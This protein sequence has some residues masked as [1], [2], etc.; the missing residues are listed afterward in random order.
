[1]H[2]FFLVLA[3]ALRGL[4]Y[5]TLKSAR[6]VILAEV[7]KH[8]LEGF[9]EILDLQMLLTRLL[10]DGGQDLIIVLGFGL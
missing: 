3:E 10:L 7:S 1:M 5:P 8:L 9:V 2:V 6:A 4:H